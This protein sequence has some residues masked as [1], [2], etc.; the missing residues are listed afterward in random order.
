MTVLAI[1]QQRLGLDEFYP[2]SGTNAQLA[3]EEYADDRTSLPS[4]R[5]GTSFVS[6]LDSLLKIFFDCAEDDWDGYSA[7]AISEPTLN[8]AFKLASELSDDLPSPEFSPE[9]DG[10]IALEWYGANSSVFSISIGESGKI[11]YAGLFPDGNSSHGVEDWSGETKVLFET[12]V[13][14]T[15]S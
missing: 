5:K 4:G 15:I 1:G 7:V 12:F 3:P 10:E 2:Q 13:R 11:N 9:P 14:R 8:S 6:R